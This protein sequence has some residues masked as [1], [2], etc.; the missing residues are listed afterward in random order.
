MSDIYPTDYDVL[1]VGA[2][3]A[4]LA[5]ADGLSGSRLSTLI[6]D[7]G[8]PLKQRDRYSAEDITQGVGGA[9]L[10]SDGKFSFFPSSTRLWQ[11]PDHELLQVAYEKAS[12]LF[13]DYGLSPPPFREGD[14]DGRDQATSNWKLKSYPCSYMSP[15][16][17]FLLTQRL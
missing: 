9:G 16:N 13:H 2:G 10:F 8:K 1:I 7:S 5:T 14:I 11:L 12:S 17:R 4:G 6:I 15:E 3:P